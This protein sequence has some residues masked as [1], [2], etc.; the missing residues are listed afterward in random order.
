MHG[1]CVERL[2][3]G[4][5]HTHGSVRNASD[6]QSNLVEQVNKLSVCPVCRRRWRLVFFLRGK[7]A[8]G[9]DHGKCETAPESN[10][11]SVAQTHQIISFFLLLSMERVPT[12]PSG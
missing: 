11:R 6:R 7:E 12:S 9:Y 10:L 3:V 4:V 8:G 1:V 2:A 5:T